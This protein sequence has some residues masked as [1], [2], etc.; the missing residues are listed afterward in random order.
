MYLTL[1]P[2]HKLMDHLEAQ[3]QA[4]S[5]AGEKEAYARGT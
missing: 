1:T 2:L 3:A 4:Y 5:S